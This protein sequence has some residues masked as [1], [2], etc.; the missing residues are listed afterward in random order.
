[1]RTARERDP[2]VLER[3]AYVRWPSVV[4][5]EPLTVRLAQSCPAVACSRRRRSSWR[6]IQCV[7]WIGVIERCVAPIIIITAAHQ[8]EPSPA[9]GSRSF[10]PFTINPL[11][12]GDGDFRNFR[13]HFP[14]SFADYPHSVH[15]SCHRSSAGTIKYNTDRRP[16]SRSIAVTP[17]S[18][19][20]PSN[21]IRPHHPPPDWERR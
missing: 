21:C 18:N 1:M 20:L 3:L 10:F 5:V 16:H 7:L 14:S 4:A 17:R 15:S 11:G 6:K 8:P 19:P 2:L 9:V 12:V 13:I